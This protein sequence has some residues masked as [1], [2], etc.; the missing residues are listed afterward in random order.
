MGSD[1]PMLAQCVIK[2][3][4]VGVDDNQNEEWWTDIHMWIQEIYAKS[5]KY[6]QTYWIEE[7][8]GKGR[9]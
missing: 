8:K 7:L 4:W 5:K 9:R 1:D 2:N 3:I 6:S